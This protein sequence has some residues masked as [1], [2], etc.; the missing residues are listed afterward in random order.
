[1]KNP[2][3]DSLV[4]G[5]F[6]LAPNILTGRVHTPSVQSQ[7]KISNILTGRVHTPPSNH[8]QKSPY[9]TLCS[10]KHVYVHVC[11]VIMEIR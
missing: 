6:T 5:L 2:Q 8:S 11:T 10:K 7:S 3:F 1:M 9:T 4:W